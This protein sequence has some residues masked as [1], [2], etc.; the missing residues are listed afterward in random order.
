MAAPT[1]NADPFA[2]TTDD[3]GIQLG[4]ASATMPRQVS[5]AL[6]SDKGSPLLHCFRVYFA[7]EFRGVVGQAS[8]SASWEA[9]RKHDGG[10]AMS[11]RSRTEA[12]KFVCPESTIAPAARESRATRKD[13]NVPT[14]VVRE[15]PTVGAR[16]TA[17][18]KGETYSL[19]F[20]EEGYRLSG[21]EL[22]GTFKS[23]STAGRAVTGRVSCE[24]PRFWAPVVSAAGTPDVE[25][26][27]A[28]SEPT[29]AVRP[30]RKRTPKA[31]TPVVA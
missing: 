7:G 22:R 15:A 14:P 10:V 2:F 3:E 24:G 30:S 25:A 17:S 26:P 19:E 12:I 13:P 11:L 29:A 27:A 9:N 6:W 28:P 8:P 31:T 21:G 16:F 23:L 18:Y 4:D 1:L 20:T 5:P